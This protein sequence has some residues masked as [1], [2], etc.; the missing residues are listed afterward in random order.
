VPV[1]GVWRALSADEVPPAVGCA[2]A[3][4]TPTLTPTNIPTIVS[5]VCRVQTTRT[6]FTYTTP[7]GA[8]IALDNNALTPLS[9]GTI[10]EVYWRSSLYSAIVEFSTPQFIPYLTMWADTS[11]GAV[12]LVS[13]NCAELSTEPYVVNNPIQ[14]PLPW[15]VYPLRV[16]NPEEQI[17]YQFA[18]GNSRYNTTAWHHP[19]IDFF[20]GNLDNPQF[21][22]GVVS[23]ENGTLV[24]YCS[25]ERTPAFDGPP[26]L[27]NASPTDCT[28][29]G[30]TRA[31]VAIRYGNSIV[32]YAHLLPTL[33]IGKRSDGVVSD[34]LIGYTASHSEGS[35]LHF[36]VRTYAA[37]GYDENQV[38]RYWVN[39]W[40][41]FDA[42]IQN[43]IITN[44][45]NRNNEDGETAGKPSQQIT[46]CFSSPENPSENAPTSRVGIRIYGFNPNDPNLDNYREF[47][48]VE[49]EIKKYPLSPLSGSWR[50]FCMP[51]SQ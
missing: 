18:M 42:F 2:V 5:G 37:T 47:R 21:G 46:Q 7:A 48:W 17:L 35:H 3:T 4:P 33:R 11:D 23:V 26:W 19:G 49:N 15:S 51:Q 9:A 6:V 10:L 20:T 12:V 8:A 29:S 34:Q 22:I 50:D 40:Q 38:P 39:G 30:G 1:V 36:E 27:A 45:E 16:L 41:Y 32:I 24:G 43:V 25:P 14:K 28:A 31:F 13:E 44:W